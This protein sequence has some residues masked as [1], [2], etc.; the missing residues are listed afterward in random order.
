MSRSR[1]FIT[2]QLAFVIAKLTC[3]A[4]LHII[5]SSS[6]SPWPSASIW[7]PAR[8]DHSLSLSHPP[9]PR[10]RPILTASEPARG[11]GS[12]PYQSSVPAQPRLFRK[13][14]PRSRFSRSGLPRSRSRLSQPGLPF[15]LWW[16]CWI[17]TLPAKETAWVGF[18]GLDVPCFALCSFLDQTRASSACDCAIGC[19]SL[20]VC[21][22]YSD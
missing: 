2:V 11:P 9:F 14:L 15:R 10:H 16:Y 17:S 3:E 22:I 19:G 13:R 12:P 8:V 4:Y 6:N 21:R 5:S 20:M 7:P 1:Y 18:A